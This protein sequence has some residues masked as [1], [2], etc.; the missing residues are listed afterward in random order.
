VYRAYLPPV[1]L[2]RE[3]DPEGSEKLSHGDEDTMSA[4]F[5]IRLATY[6]AGSGTHAAAV[7]S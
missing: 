5:A 1:L 7:H 4:N 2:N 6:I 3:L